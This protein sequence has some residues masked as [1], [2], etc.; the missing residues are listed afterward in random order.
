MTLRAPSDTLAR[1]YSGAV[2]RLALAGL[3]LISAACKV[4]APTPIADDWTDDFERPDLGG[5]YFASGKGY[6]LVR[7]EL[8]ARGAKNHPL[9]L[10][11]R[12][13]RDVRIDFDAW[14]NDLRGDIK[15]EVFGDGRSFDPDGGRYMA[16]GYELIFGGWS[17]SKSI[18]ARMDEHADNV[19]AR[20]APKVVPKQ[21]YHWR[22]E[23]Q[24]NVVRW[25]VDDMDTPFL[26]F[27]DP[28]PLEGPGHEYFAFNNWETDTWFDNL[29]VTAL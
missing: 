16:S 28:E 8:S 11:K 22:I 10:R 1:G 25:F 19:K 24:E 18:I 27:D 12:L 15:I 23:R 21:H 4:D 14:S 6:E 26:T 2:I 17:N 9:W 13:P 3:A 5:N 7:G 20:T 29:V